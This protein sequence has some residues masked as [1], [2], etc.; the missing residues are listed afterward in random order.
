MRLQVYAPASIL[1]LFE[2]LKLEASLVL[3]FLKSVCSIEVMELRPGQAQPQLLFSCSV[4]NRTQEVLQQRAMFT[5]AVSAPL[6][7][8]VSGAYQLELELK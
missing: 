6:D 1:A 5:T 7:Q 8:Q 3:L 4:V 2:D